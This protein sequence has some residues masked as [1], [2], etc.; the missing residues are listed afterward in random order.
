MVTISSTQRR[1]RQR[2]KTC[3]R[4]TGS[5]GLK[6]LFVV[7]VAIG[8]ALIVWVYYVS[9][10]CLRE[11]GGRDGVDEHDGA[12]SKIRRR[13]RGSFHLFPSN[14]IYDDKTQSKLWPSLADIYDGKEVIRDPQNKIFVVEI[15][16]LEPVADPSDTN[17][18]Q[19]K[20]QLKDDLTAF[21]GLDTA[22]QDNPP[23]VVPGKKWSPESQAIRDKR[24]MNICQDQYKPLRE[25]LMRVSR[26][27]ATWILESFMHSEDVY[28]SSPD[29]F[30]ECI[31]TWMY[32][33]C[34]N[35][36][37]HR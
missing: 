25:E 36:S 9:V 7:Q 21:L 26:I 11:K 1:Q 3:D 14:N 15:R 10:T 37:V 31:R 29:F 6:L 8:S 23:R 18:I 5:K 32:D 16:Q 22:L 12:L 19:R 35:D 33:P 13:T 2:L 17:A 20:E 4:E 28:T 34:E 30:Q 27:T 24:K